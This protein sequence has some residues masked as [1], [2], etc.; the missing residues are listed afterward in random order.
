MALPSVMVGQYKQAL[1]IFESDLELSR[2]WRNKTRLA[3][4]LLNIAWVR[5]FVEDFV[6]AD[7]DIDESLVYFR[8]AG[9]AEGEATAFI[10]MGHIDA[11]QDKFVPARSHFLDA[12]RIAHSIQALPKLAEA[13]AGLALF[14]YELDG[15][16]ELAW[17]I[18]EYCKQ[19][20]QPGSM[21]YSRAETVLERIGDRVTADRAAIL[22]ETVDG[23]DLNRLAMA[24]LHHQFDSL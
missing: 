6:Q 3:T 21:T 10:V 18:S 1:E 23:Y 9:N 4:I 19:N 14:I 15:E 2:K 5:S 8:E 17:K 13:I 22:Q 24:M 11:V 16:V 20:A 7:E 12:V